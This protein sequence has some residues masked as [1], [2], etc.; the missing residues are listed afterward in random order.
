MWPLNNREEYFM[1]RICGKICK[2]SQNGLEEYFDSLKY[3][4]SKERRTLKNGREYDA[5]TWETDHGAF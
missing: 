5:Y 4:V 2:E 1:D 3:P